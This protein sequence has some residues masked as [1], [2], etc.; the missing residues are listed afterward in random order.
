MSDTGWISPGTMADDDTVGTVAW[1]NPDNA[2]ASDDSYATTTPPGQGTKLYTH[3]LKATNFSFSIPSGATIDGILVELEVVD[4]SFYNS[5]FESKTY[6][7][8]ADGSYGTTNKATTDQ[9]L[10]TT[11]AYI[12]FGASDELWG[13]TWTSANINDSDFGV[14]ISV[15]YSDDENTADI[16]ADHIRIKVYYTESGVTSAPFP[17]FF[18]P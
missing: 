14:G 11:E 15:V 10:P 1:N 18:R 4:D 17:M 6:I 13:E 8:K 16:K 9:L 3:Y 5:A 7:V 12:S 2:K